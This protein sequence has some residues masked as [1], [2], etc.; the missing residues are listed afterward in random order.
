[1]LAHMKHIFQQYKAIYTPTPAP[2]IVDATYT[3]ASGYITIG[4]N[5]LL[6]TWGAG[7][8]TWLDSHTLNA[9]WQNYSHILRFPAD[10]KTFFSA[11][12]SDFDIVTGQLC[13]KIRTLKRNTNLVYFSIF[14]NSKYFKLAKVLLKSLRFFSSTDVDIL[15]LTSPDFQKEAEEL[16]A[17]LPIR[18]HYMPFTTIFQAACAR[19]HIF[20]YPDIQQYQKI[21][22][23]DTD[24]VI[25][26]DLVPLFAEP[27]T[28]LL[29]GLG[30]GTISSVSF[31]SQFFDF[32]AIDGN[33]T[34]INSG[35]LLF[36]NCEVVR[37]LF[38]RINAH[39][40]AYKDPVPYTMDQP[41]INFHAIRDKLYD[42][43]LMHPHVT[44]YEGENVE[45]ST[46]A[47]ICHFSFPI[48][49]SDHKYA[50]M[51]A[52]LRA[53]LTRTGQHTGASF[54]HTSFVWGANGTITFGETNRLR[55]PWGDGTYEIIGENRI[56][57]KWG[58]W[59]HVIQFEADHSCG[60]SL[61][62]SPLDFDM[63][64]VRLSNSSGPAP[65]AD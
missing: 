16:C 47:S 20:D 56:C 45:Y 13:G 52:F 59:E 6:T 9:T 50:R 29:Y 17:I 63:T 3:W 61:R 14:Y 32:S 35:T 27:L 46:T 48:G 2:L 4:T 7:T 30:S 19:L 64:I 36:N 31:G 33:T 54:V 5:G 60:L 44:L 34:G 25:K 62:I 49:N 24:I 39:I 37:S 38:A 41:F 23:L 43:A 8:Y 53:E 58:K 18:I 11:R 40:A 12:T 21:L 42:T 28:D 51:E 55:T 15:L 57:A 22:Y 26:K 65:T 10:Y 1:M